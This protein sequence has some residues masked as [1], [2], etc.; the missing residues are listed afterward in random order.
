MSARG[1]LNPL[2]IALAFLIGV[3]FLMMSLAGG[4]GAA[5]GLEAGEAVYGVL[6][7]IGLFAFLIGSGLWVFLV[8]PWTQFDDINVPKDTGHHAHDDAGGH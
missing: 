5:F 3:G 7:V 1:T 4:V 8:K 2:E 6:F